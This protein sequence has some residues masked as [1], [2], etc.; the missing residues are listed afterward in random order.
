MEYMGQN[1][2]SDSVRQLADSFYDRFDYESLGL[3]NKVY[4]DSSLP[5]GSVPVRI[6]TAF[7]S[8]L[9][10]KPVRVDAFDVL[11]GQL[12]HYDLSASLPYRYDGGLDPASQPING[13]NN[14]STSKEE[15]TACKRFLREISKEDEDSLDLLLR[16]I[17]CGYFTH[18]ANGHVI[19]GYKNILKYGYSGLEKK[20][21]GQLAG[22]QKNKERQYLEAMLIVVLGAKKYITRY[23]EAALTVSENANDDKRANLLQIEQGCRNLAKGAP[24]TFFEAIQSAL[25]FQEM[26]LMESASGSISMGRLDQLFYPYYK[27]DL[28]LGLITEERAQELIDAWRVKLASV[29]AGYQNLAIGG[30]GRDGKFAGNDITRMILRSTMRLRYDQPLLSLRYTKDTPDDFFEEAVDLIALGDGFPA[31]FNDEIIIKALEQKGIAKEDA[32]DYGLVGCVEPSIMGREF[33]NTEEMRINWGKVLELMLNGGV[34][35]MTGRCFEMKRRLLPE[36]ISTFGELLGWFK[37]ELGHVIHQAAHACNLIDSVYHQAYPAVLMSLSMDGCIENGADVGS[38]NGTIY[39]YSTINHTGMA[40]LVDSLIAIKKLVFDEGKLTLAKFKEILDADFKGHD[41]IYYEVVNRCPKFGNDLS[42]PD[43]LM[44]ELVDWADDVV[45][46]IPNC[47]G[48]HFVSGFYSVEHHG[49]MGARMGALPDGKRAGAALANG[50][51]P[52][53][54]ADAKGPTAVINSSTKCDHARFGNGMVLDLKFSPSFFR[55]KHRRK[56]FRPLTQTYFDKGGMELQLNVIDRKTLLDAQAHP[57]LYKNLI[58]R[59]SGFSAYFVTL[60]KVLQD[61]IIARTEYETM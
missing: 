54:G 1:Y 17:E 37:D 36:Q 8:F 3:R 38:P 49:G 57:G 45:G 4:S 47:R 23:A 41:D 56:M 5:D 51:C 24:S 53:Q 18:T 2:T 21:R 12:Q 46:S 7:S 48:A 29:T 33:S 10:Q 59:V 58:V 14:L 43:Q 39:R 26:L 32:W 60:S 13:N 19:P 30:R 22:A 15:V 55:D 9:A 61:E 28:G 35:R 27:K 25:L 42:E 20:I 31:L 11:A 40:N 44:K 6:A 52:V 50:F 16:G 34:C